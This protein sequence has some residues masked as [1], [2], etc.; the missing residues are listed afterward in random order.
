MHPTGNPDSKSP[1][2]PRRIK[3][4]SAGDITPKVRFEQTTADQAAQ[5]AAKVNNN[6]AGGDKTEP[7]PV[8]TTTSQPTS[9]PGLVPPPGLAG[10]WFTSVNPGQSVSH[11]PSAF[12]GHPQ[13]LQQHVGFTQIPQYQPTNIAIP[14]NPVVYHP[15]FTMAADYQNTGPP[16]HGLNFQP[17]VPDTTFGPMN[18]VYI[19]RF[20]NGVAGAPAAYAQPVRYPPRSVHFVPTAPTYATVMMPQPQLQPQPQVIYVQTA[21]PQYSYYVS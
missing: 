19:P 8:T 15:N 7:I 16:P 6:T 18:H 10:Q 3:T 9:F 11:P 14:G 5:A 2:T 12:P 21:Y 20:D 13:S 17:P 4:T 1:K